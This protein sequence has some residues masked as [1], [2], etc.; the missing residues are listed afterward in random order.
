MRER[1]SLLQP[2]QPLSGTQRPK[3]SLLPPHSR[4]PIPRSIRTLSARWSPNPATCRAPG[5][6]PPTRDPR[7]ARVFTASTALEPKFQRGSRGEVGPL[8]PGRGLRRRAAPEA[9]DH[10]G[11]RRSGLPG[12][13]DEPGAAALIRPGRRAAAQ[14]LVVRVAAH[15]PLAPE[16]RPRMCDGLLGSRARCLMASWLR[17]P[18]GEEWRE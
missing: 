9:V 2:Q 18:A 11:H 5:T 17:P 8:A 7:R 13:L 12:H 16:A 1:K 3:T 15:V 10:G 14:L 4:A 6:R